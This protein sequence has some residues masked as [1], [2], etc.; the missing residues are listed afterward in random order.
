MEADVHSVRRQKD[1]VNGMSRNAARRL[2]VVI[3]GKESKQTARN[4]WKVLGKYRCAPR[5]RANNMQFFCIDVNVM[6][7]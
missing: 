2:Y 7:V 5:A 6:H 3:Q 1:A 4:G